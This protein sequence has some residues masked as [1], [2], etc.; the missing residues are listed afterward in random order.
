MLSLGNVILTII[1]YHIKG[2][3]PCDCHVE[4]GILPL[5]LI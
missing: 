4:S 2:L 3:I 1:L 5:N